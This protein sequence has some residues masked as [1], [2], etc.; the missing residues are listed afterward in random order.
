MS[1]RVREKSVPE[2]KRE[3]QRERDRER[4]IKQ[5]RRMFLKKKNYFASIKL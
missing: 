1:G 5:E 3:A 4:E 2:I